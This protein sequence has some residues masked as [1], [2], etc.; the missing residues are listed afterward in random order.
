MAVMIEC[1][2]C[3]SKF[4]QIESNEDQEK[5]VYQITESEITSI[6]SSNRELSLSVNS[7][8]TDL[9]TS[10]KQWEIK[11]VEMQK[12]LNKQIQKLNDKNDQLEQRLI[13]LE[14]F[15]K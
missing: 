10:N 6:I 14:K 11:F 15:L 8:K 4:F 9:E 5:Q 1:P 2:R 7:L 13:M 12:S 3:K